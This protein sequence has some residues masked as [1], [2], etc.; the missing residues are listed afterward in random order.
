MRKL[1]SILIILSTA[2]CGGGSG[3]APVL[4]PPPVVVN[5]DP[6]GFWTGTLANE[7][8]TFEELVGITTA[9]GQFTLIS[10]DTFGPDTFAQYIGNLT[11]VGSDISGSGKAYAEPGSTW[12]NGSVVLDITL[13]AIV[14]EQDT[15]SGLLQNS[16]GETV[17]FELDYD[18]E[19]EKP[20][21]IG[22]LEGTWYV[23]NEMLNPTLTLTVQADGSFSGQNSIG[24]HSLGQVTIIDAG[25][26]VYGWDV[27][28]SGCGIFGDYSGVAVLGD[29]VTGD[30]ANSQDNLVL[31][32][33][34]NAQRALLLPLE[35]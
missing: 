1:I 6:G 17:T 26:N 11:V 27:T 3:G 5:A 7:D 28:I 15:M 9:D 12:G 24:C 21:S 31:V 35:R 8:M 10:V 25:F 32:S 23:Y 29:I 22:L 34:S 2:A 13:T 33:I 30:P 20:S 19:Y 4:R 14:N 16:I 18:P